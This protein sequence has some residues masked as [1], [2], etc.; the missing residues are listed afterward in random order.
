MVHSFLNEG[1]RIRL[2]HTFPPH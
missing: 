2:L 1:T